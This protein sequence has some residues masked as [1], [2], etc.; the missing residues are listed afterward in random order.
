MQ[1]V[2]IARDAKDEDALER[3]MSARAAHIALCDAAEAS[4]RQIYGAA[5]L[6]DE[7]TMCGSI[8]VFDMESRAELDLYLKNEPYIVNNVWDDIE[9]IACRT[10]PSFMKKL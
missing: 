3:R 6:N 7:G 5:L 10:G 9:I 1:F 8:M 2:V 4:G